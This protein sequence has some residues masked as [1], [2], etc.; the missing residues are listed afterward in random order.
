MSWF[1]KKTR[2]SESLLTV[3]ATAE[4]TPDA[5]RDLWQ[6]LTF[7]ERLLAEAGGAGSA[8]AR[9]LHRDAEGKAQARPVGAGLRVGRASD[10]DVQV[11]SL[12]MSRRHFELRSQG[13][14]VF[15]QDLRSRSGTYVNNVR[16]DTRELRDGDIISAGEQ[17]F[18][19]LGELESVGVIG[20]CG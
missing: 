18:V 10:A 6:R 14:K 11:N 2:F 16:V 1:G 5:A 19:F 17:V 8:G 12:K 9:L 7:V 15:L 4:V 20:K 3:A 13:K